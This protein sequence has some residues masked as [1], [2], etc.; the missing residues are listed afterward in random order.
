MKRYSLTYVMKRFGLSSKYARK[1]L[2]MWCE[3]TD[4]S[5]EEFYV[6]PS[7]GNKKG[8]FYLPEEFVR[9][10]EEY[11]TKV[12]SSYR[13]KKYFLELKKGL[14]VKTL[15]DLARELGLNPKL[16]RRE[17]NW[18]C[19]MH[20]VNKAELWHPGIG[21]VIPSEFE[22]YVKKVVVRDV[23]SRPVLTAPGPKG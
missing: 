6:P 7:Q 15:A 22:E 21:Y 5:V 3:L 8:R 9:W 19:E 2:R 4:H 1:Y 14:G 12:P 17:F 23:Q 16:L 13:R 11:L 18:W 20:G 10:L